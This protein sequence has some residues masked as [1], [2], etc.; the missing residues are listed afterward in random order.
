MA[1]H[2]QMTE[3][4]EGLFK[5]FRTAINAEQNAQRMYKEAEAICDDEDIRTILKAFIHEESSHERILVEMYE[6]FSK[7]HEIQ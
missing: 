6:G 3:R 1:V 4:Q 2:L 7:K 5:I